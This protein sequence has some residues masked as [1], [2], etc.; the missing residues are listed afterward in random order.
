M[1]RWSIVEN[2]DKILSYIYIYYTCTYMN[3]RWIDKIENLVV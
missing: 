1:T 2:I 3:K